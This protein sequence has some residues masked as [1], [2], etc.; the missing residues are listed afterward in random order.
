[1]PLLR[2]VDLNKARHN[3]QLFITLKTQLELARI[4]QVR[5]TSVLAEID[6]A[7]VPAM[8]RPRRRVLKTAT[9]FLATA[10]L[11][12]F[13]IFLVDAPRRRD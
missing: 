2:K 7:T 12:T 9:A 5:S 1:M 11:L 13:L 10:G 8:P 6:P 4:E 3:E